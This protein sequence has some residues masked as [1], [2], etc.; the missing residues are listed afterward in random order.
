MLLGII[1]LII[2]VAGVIAL[3]SPGDALWLLAVFIGIGWIFQ[4]FS[5]LYAAITKSGHSPTWY[6]I[7][8]G[9]VSVIA[10]IVMLILPVFSLEVLTWVGGIMLVAISIATLLTLPKKVEGPAAPAA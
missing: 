10:G 7:V 8:S 1:G 9:I 3:F 6:L 4:G 5:D 2:L